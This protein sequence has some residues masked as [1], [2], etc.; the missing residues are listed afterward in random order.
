MKESAGSELS[1]LLKQIGLNIRNARE[2]QSLSQAEVCRRAKI[3]ITRLSE[4]ESK[5]SRDIRI[6]TLSSLARVLGVSISDL[7]QDQE[8][9]FTHQEQVALLKA[10]ESLVKITRRFSEK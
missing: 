10:S 2:E 9:D 5:R 3:S 4:I 8:T 7:L 1:S 6:S